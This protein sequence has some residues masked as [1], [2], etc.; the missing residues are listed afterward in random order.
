MDV[1]L[2]AMACV[3]DARGHTVAAIS[4]DAR[5]TA[6]QSRQEDKRAEGK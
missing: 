3:V 6:A 5:A 4:F 2:D 1:R